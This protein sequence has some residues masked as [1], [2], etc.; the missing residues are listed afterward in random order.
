M[1]VHHVANQDKGKRFKPQYP[2]VSLIGLFRY[3]DS[4]DIT[5]M[6]VGIILSAAVGIA[7]PLNTYFFRDQINKFLSPNFKESDAHPILVQFACLGAATFVAAFTASA[8]LDLSSK[9]QLQ[10]IRLKYFKAV[11]KQ[12]IPWS[13]QRSAG[14]LISNLSD[15]I[16]TIELGIGKK[17]GEFFQNM[18]GFL[19]GIIIALYIGW[20]LTLVACSTLPVVAAVFT[21]FAFVMKFFTKKELLAY[22][23]ASSIS[24]EVLTAIRTIVAFGGEQKEIERYSKELHKAEKVGIQK[25]IAVGGVTGC[26][27]LS[28]YCAAALIFWYGFK[29]IDEDNYDA[30]SVILVF[31]NVVLGSIFL[32]NALP[33]MRYF[34][35]AKTAAQTI[36]GTIERVPPI[37]KDA[38]GLIVDNFQGNIQ[39][40]NVSFV[41]PTRPEVKILQNFNLTLKSGQTVALVGPSGSGKSTIIHMLQRFYDPEVGNILIE[42][43]NIRELNLKTYRAQIGCVQQEP[44]LFEGTIA[45]N[46]R[47]GKL[48]A[49]EEEI[50]EAA[51]EANAHEFIS[52]LPDGYNTLVAERGGGMSGGQKQRIAIA[53]ALI[54]KPKLLLL[55]EATSALDT[56]SEREVQEALERASEGRTVVV[57]AHRLTTVRNADLIMVLEK[58]YIRESGTHDQ[59]V[60]LDGLY[61]TML[62]NQKKSEAEDEHEDEFDGQFKPAAQYK[63]KE[64]KTPAG[65]WRIGDQEDLLSETIASELTV[66]QRISIIS[67]RMKAR[68]SKMRSSP[69][70]R[71]LRLNRPETG[72]IIGGCIS[73][74]IAGATVPSFAVLYS[75]VYNVF[76][77]PEGSE[78]RDKINL[79]CGMM[80]LVGF[81]RFF[82]LLLQ[83]YFFGVSGE[84]LTRRV[85]SQYFEAMLRQRMLLHFTSQEI[86]W[87]DKSEN[88]PG[89]LT[90]KLAAE[91]SKLRYISGSEVGTI[92][93]AV[94]VTVVSWVIA[95]VYGWQLALVFLVFYPLIVLTGVAQVQQLNRRAGGDTDMKSMRLAQEAISNSRTV[96]TL[97]LEDF[98]YEKF[99]SSSSSNFKKIMKACLLNALM[100]AVTQ[101]VFMFAFAAVFALGAHLVVEKTLD[102]PAM[103]RVFAVMNMSAQTLGRL[104]SVVPDSRKAEQSSRSIFATIDRIPQIQTDEGLMPDREFKGKVT[105]KNVY[106]RYP[107]RREARI[108]KNFSHT[109]EPN[110]TVALVGQSGCGKSTLLQLVQRFYD[111][112]DHGEDSGVYFDEWNLRDLAPSWIRKQIGVVSQEPNLLD[113]TLRENIA[114]GDNTREVSTDEIIE[115]ARQA[116]AHDFIS[117]LPDGY[118]TLAGVSG[119]QLSGG[120]KQ[121]IAIARALIRKP[122]LL[123]LDEATSALDNESE[124]IVQEALD[125]A[126]GSRTSIVVAHRLTTVERSDLIVVLDSG[127]KIEC[128]PPAALME[129][130]GAFY[131]LHCVEQPS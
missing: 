72:F 67:Q 66:G 119:S 95:F 70:F 63:V 48:D 38:D 124:R 24:G 17:V 78:K 16:D 69:V 68:C 57:V 41:Y 18:S 28:I 121:R 20:K 76:L 113:M 56:R 122:K 40:E 92:M 102:P 34:L 13:D 100:Y 47:M 19:S 32:G 30:G 75:E 7:F 112:S 131:A 103:F 107:T 93:E 126:T 33:T 50:K 86:G 53:R 71:V 43:E 106:F 120:Q 99:N 82:A 22:A 59:L 11:L 44:I 45:E 61:A 118:E 1:S 129:T 25:S 51:K 65:I 8:L 74:V 101:S 91:A 6:V 31:V 77:M 58:G 9:R 110:Q 10:R 105:F 3:A 116:N 128:G 125:A 73:C 98:F 94:V 115:A 81:L 15:C 130:K 35:S 64:E 109:V 89:A 87:F 97:I 54:R 111:P 4:K 2:P 46:I 5:S 14:E 123:L 39:F 27:G 60:A 42:G 84:R 52:K 37:D 127:R 36:Y 83:G 23:K 55:D 29:L 12:D 117:A 114:Y 79:I 90:A 49:T 88:Q 104:A 108:L 62:K 80:A 85:R 26:I 21:S 96:T